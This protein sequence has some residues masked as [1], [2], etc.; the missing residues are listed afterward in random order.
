MCVCG[1]VGCVQG[2]R[3]LR[4]V[5]HLPGG[6]ARKTRMSRRRSFKN[7]PTPASVPPVPV[8]HVNPS[9][10]PRVCSQISGLREAAWVGAAGGGHACPSHRQRRAAPRRLVVPVAVGDVVELIG[11]HGWGG[12]GAGRAR[13]ETRWAVL[14]RADTP[15]PASANPTH[16]SRAPLRVFAPGGC[17]SAGRRTAPPAPAAPPR[18]ACVAG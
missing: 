10:L 8:A 12:A 1:G 16:R 9:T 17:S 7:A 5:P 11:P 6:S 4:W 3:V 18:P 14:V 13:G 15:H 2:G